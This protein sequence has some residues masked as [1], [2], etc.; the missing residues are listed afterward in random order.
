[1]DAANKSPDSKVCAPLQSPNKTVSEMKKEG[2]EAV[3]E[4]DR[5]ET[6][7]ESN[8]TKVEPVAKVETATEDAAKKAGKTF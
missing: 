5:V 6:K 3:A 4:V 7:V 8:E 1:M 2:E